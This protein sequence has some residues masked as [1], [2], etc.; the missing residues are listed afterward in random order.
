MSNTN[1]NTPSIYEC[2][3]CHQKFSSISLLLRH[4]K[5]KHN[6]N[7]FIPHRNSL[8]L[9]PPEL[10]IQYQNAFIIHIKKRLEHSVS[11]KSL[12]IDALPETIFVHLFEYEPTF[13]YSPAQREYYCEFQGKDGEERL[14]QILNCE[15][16]NFQQDK[17]T[18]Y[19]LNF[20]WSLLELNENGRNLKC[21]ITTCT[22][23]VDSREENKSETIP[24]PY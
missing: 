7:K 23:M 2:L 15:Y 12:S 22:F 18:G 9:P 19:G 24:P 21:G 8:Y 17:T 1:M 4:E 13:R 11:S 3:L 14:K 16:W 20:N 6:D 10:I 5:S